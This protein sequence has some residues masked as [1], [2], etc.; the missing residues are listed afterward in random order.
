MLG[1]ESLKNFVLYSKHLGLYREIYIGIT[2]FTKGSSAVLDTANFWRHNLTIKP[3]AEI[4]QY[5][6]YLDVISNISTLGVMLLLLNIGKSTAF[7]LIRVL[8]IILI[9]PYLIVIDYASKY[10]EYG[11]LYAGGGDLVHD[12]DSSMYFSLVN[13]TTLGYGDV[14]PATQLRIFATS[15]AI[16]GQISY[17]MSIAAIAFLFLKFVSSIRNDN[18]YYDDISLVVNK[19]RYPEKPG[20]TEDERGGRPR[21][22]SRMSSKLMRQVRSAQRIRV[23]R[24]A[25]KSRRVH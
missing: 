13:W 16:A 23:R 15:E 4:S 19:G 2:L 20:E 18:N 14:L 22:Y 10:F 17:T 9:I 7:N 1:K 25:L 21:R 12:Y 6:I 8:L 3:I 24:Q 5:S 11:V